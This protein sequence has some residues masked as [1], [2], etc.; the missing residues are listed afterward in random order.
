MVV[1]KTLPTLAKKIGSQ[2]LT[3]LHGIKKLVVDS[4]AVT[5]CQIRTVGEGGNPK[6]GLLSPGGK[7]QTLL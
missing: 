5:G 4:L 2:L 1:L 7:V 3:R 6:G